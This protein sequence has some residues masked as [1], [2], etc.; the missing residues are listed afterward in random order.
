MPRKKKIQ[1]KP[2]ETI[3]FEYPDGEIIDFVRF[4]NGVRVS[5]NK[6]GNIITQGSNNALKH[7]DLVDRVFEWVA[8]KYLSPQGRKKIRRGEDFM[9]TARE[10]DQAMAKSNLFP[11]V[12]DFG[13]VRKRI[14]PEVKRR[15]DAVANALDRRDNPPCGIA[16][17]LEEKNQPTVTIKKGTF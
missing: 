12:D 2:V 11:E 13:A 3:R 5:L 15:I 10:L 1:P 8:G 16:A 4:A 7:D 9:N 17:I 6:E 14:C